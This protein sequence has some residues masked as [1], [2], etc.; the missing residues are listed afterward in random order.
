MYALPGGFLSPDT[1]I[2]ESA[3]REVKEET[4]LHVSNLASC[5]VSE[6]VFDHPRR[7]ARGRTV[8]HGF[9]FELNGGGPLPTVKG[10]DDAAEALWVPL[11]DLTLLEENF[12]EDHLHII[13]H[14]LTHK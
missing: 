9:F 6:H 10:G 4:K 2:F 5:L 11:N 13:Q 3:L 14:F 8:T 12:F 1:S 7:S